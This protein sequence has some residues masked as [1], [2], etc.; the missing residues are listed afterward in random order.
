MPVDA[1]AFVRPLEGGS[2]AASPR[3]ATSAL[4]ARTSRFTS[5][6][7]SSGARAGSSVAALVVGVEGFGDLVEGTEQLV[8][9]D[10]LG[11]A[12]SVGVVDAEVRRTRQLIEATSGVRLIKWKLRWVTARKQKQIRAERSGNAGPRRPGPSWAALSRPASQST[13]SASRSMWHQG[14]TAYEAN[15]DPDVDVV[16]F[17]AAGKAHP[18]FSLWRVRA[19]SPACAAWRAAW[20]VSGCGELPGRVGRLVTGRLPGAMSSASSSSA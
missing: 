2:A 8:V 9:G 19:A 5:S 3:C 11:L 1:W 13:R 4:L 14:G 15:L 16:G 6:W 20:R 17:R 10:L 7:R 12:E 18:R